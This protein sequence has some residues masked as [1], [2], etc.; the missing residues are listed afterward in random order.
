MA[1]PNNTK[2]IGSYWE[3]KYSLTEEE[4]LGWVEELDINNLQTPFSS[5]TYKTLRSFYSFVGRKL[6]TDYKILFY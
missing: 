5:K 4:I 2:N 6:S 1:K 3:E